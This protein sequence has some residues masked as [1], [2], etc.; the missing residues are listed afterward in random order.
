MKNKKWV[1]IL[2]IIAI[3]VALLVALSHFVVLPMMKNFFMNSWQDKP[4]IYLYP[5]Q[6]TDIS[7]KLDYNGELTCTYPDYGSGWNVT[8][9][10]DGRLVNKV[11]GQ[12]YSYLF[13]EGIS[14]AANYDFSKGFVVPGAET[15]TF[16]RD[17]LSLLGLTPAEYNEF[18]VFWLPRMQ[19]NPYNLITFQQERY[20]DNAPLTITP[21]PDSM[22]RVFMAYKPLEQ[23]ISIEPQQLDTFD[24]TGFA[25]VEWGG[26]E[27]Q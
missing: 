14:N 20:S 12:E 7:V 23:A 6:K 18:I 17:K 1:K 19:D 13:W 25:V 9:E 24:R 22:L 11:D 3:V 21:M 27:V 10:P 26:S 2:V 16:L 4:V 8:A 5:E 15:A